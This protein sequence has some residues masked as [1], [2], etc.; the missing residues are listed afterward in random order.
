M[1]NQSN[2]IIKALR[3]YYGAT[4]V[5]FSDF[6]NVSQG[7]LS[8]IE[9]GKLEVSAHQWITICDK[10]KINPTALMSGVINTKGLQAEETATRKYFRSFKVPKKYSL[11]AESTVRTVYPFIKFMESKLG[12]NKTVEFLKTLGF[13]QEYFVILENPINLVFINDLTSYLMKEGYLNQ[14]NLSEL[15]RFFPVNEIHS[16]VLEDVKFASNIQTA[17]VK[18]VSSISE[19]YERN[20]MYEFVGDK[21]SFIQARD[22]DHVKEFDLN[23][24]FN[25]FRRMYNAKY[26]ENLCSQF[27][28]ENIA[29]TAKK[30][31]NGWDIAYVS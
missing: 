16:Y 12:K 15:F 8:K 6:L 2:L 9:A 20:T 3:K 17:L 23:S 26:F 13:Q 10:Y 1:E 4:Q 31:N 22:N 30:V 5:E 28:L 7:A 19:H 21:N 29:L 25:S 11:Y 18:F 27:R 14:N 24:E